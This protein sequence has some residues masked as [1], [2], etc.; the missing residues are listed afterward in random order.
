MVKVVNNVT[1]ETIKYYANEE[2]YLG[3]NKLTA[4]NIYN[5]VRLWLQSR[6]SVVIGGNIYKKGDFSKII[7]REL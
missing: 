6:N 5:H 1:M 4:N 3:W 2:K 7:Y